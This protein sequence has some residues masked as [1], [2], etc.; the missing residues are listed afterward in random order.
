MFGVDDAIIG[1]GITA[2]ASLFGGSQANAATAKQNSE[3][4]YVNMMEYINNMNWSREQFDRTLQFNSDQAAH[5]RDWAAGQ[6]REAEAFNSAE[7]QKN[8][9]FQENMSNTAYQRAMA[10]M[11]AAGLNPILAAGGP[12]ASTPSGSSAS[13]GAVSGPTASAGG[14]GT[15]AG[16]TARGAVMQDVLGPAV[17]S[18][19]QAYKLGSDLETAR[20][21]RE[22][23]KASTE[24]VESQTSYNLQNA[25]NA[26][27]VGRRLKNEADASEYAVPLAQQQVANTAASVDESMSRTRGNTIRNK[28]ES[29]VG[30]G[31]L[32]N[33]GTYLPSLDAVRDWYNSP[34]TPRQ[35]PKDVPRAAL[36]PVTSSNASPVSESTVGSSAPNPASL[37]SLGS[38]RRLIEIGQ[39]RY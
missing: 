20:V 23:V 31:D 36:P 10:S 11:R 3:A 12:G 30:T 32:W 28:R 25:L 37:H 34:D 38:Y 9:D 15:P 2:G 22:Q 27:E 1:A 5:G 17:A 16:G 35:S 7:A 33:A 24:N 4:N 8:R 26:K 13:V 14:V 18:A 19:M 21:Q 29:R 39:R 6:Q